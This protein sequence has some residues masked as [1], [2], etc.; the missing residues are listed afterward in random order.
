MLVHG[1]DAVVTLERSWPID[2]GIRPLL[3]PTGYV[4]GGA[5]VSAQEHVG[6]IVVSGGSSTG[7]IRLYR[8]AVAAAAL[9]RDLHWRVLVGAGVDEAEFGA[10]A[11]AA[12]GH[13]RVERAR[14][15]F[16]ALLSGCAVSV[17]QLGYNTAVDLLRTKPR[18][19][20]APFEAD[21]LETEQ[22]LRAE[23]LSTLGW[24]EMIVEAE[25]SPESLAAAVRRALTRP[26]RD[27]VPIG[28]DGAQ[29]SV[30]IVEDLLR[31]ATA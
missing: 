4:D 15:D 30:A 20:F 9:V 10:I 17:S 26:R 28:L 21:G 14:A 6:D 18:A 8:T 12:P 2:D 24:G 13:M 25:L 31:R 19:V 22:R 7:G 23:R 3:R 16:R 1:D 11:A 27:P 5:P 29:R